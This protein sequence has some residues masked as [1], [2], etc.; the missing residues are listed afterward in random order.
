MYLTQLNN[1][2]RSSTPSFIRVCTLL[3][4]LE[5]VVQ[6]TD[7]PDLE[8]GHDRVKTGIRELTEKVDIKEEVKVTLV[9]LVK[10]MCVCACI[11]SYRDF[12]NS[13]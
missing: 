5:L 12:Q 4:I 13:V 2:L 7:G 6:R 1:S 10:R 9:S 11:L 8:K 3:V